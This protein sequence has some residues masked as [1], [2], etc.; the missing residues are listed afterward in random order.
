MH[1]LLSAIR[2]SPHEYLAEPSLDALRH[3]QG[4]YWHRMVTEGKTENWGQTRWAFHKWLCGRF[5]LQYAESTADTTIV[6]SFSSSQ[7][8]AF[9]MYFALLEEYL[10]VAGPIDEAQAIEVERMDFA[11]MMVAIRQ[12]PALYLGRATF[13]G[14]SS[15]LMGDER[16]CMDLKLSAEESR[17]IFKEFQAWVEREKSHSSLRRPW[18][19]VIEYCAWGIDCGHTNRGAW[20]IFWEWLDE[21]TGSIGQPNLF[22]GIAEASQTI[23]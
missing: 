15:Y 13:L 2:D 23:Q 16:A 14:F 6:T 1:P 11:Q 9:Q 19:K 20:S 18:F 12:R 8:D 21:Y 17:R 22:G 7:A 10:S 5:H 4:G 3:F